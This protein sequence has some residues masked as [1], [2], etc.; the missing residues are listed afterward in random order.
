MRVLP[1]SQKSL[2]PLRAACWD[3]AALGRALAQDVARACAAVCEQ[4]TAAIQQLSAYFFTTLR[5]RVTDCVRDR[6]GRKSYATASP[7]LWLSPTTALKK[8]CPPL[9][10]RPR[11]RN[12]SLPQLR[13][14]NGLV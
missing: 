2:A 10:S 3:N 14:P 5:Y 11:R 7:N 8:P 6:L 13:L 12:P 4:Y 1:L 9:T